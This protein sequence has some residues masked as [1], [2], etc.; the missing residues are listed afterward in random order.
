MTIAAATV[1]AAVTTYG[2][3]HLKFEFLPD[4]SVYILAE[5]SLGVGAAVQRCICSRTICTT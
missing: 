3:S 1:T 4:L 5:V 2:G